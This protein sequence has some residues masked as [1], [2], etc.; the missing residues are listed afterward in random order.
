MNLLGNGIDGGDLP[1]LRQRVE[2][3]GAAGVGAVVV[4]GGSV[5]ERLRILC[6]ELRLWRRSSPRSGRCVILV[7]LLKGLIML[8]VLAGRSQARVDHLLPTA[9]P[10]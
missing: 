6:R 2:A 1:H 10:V 3:F 4:R 8:S 9:Q 5:A 7:K